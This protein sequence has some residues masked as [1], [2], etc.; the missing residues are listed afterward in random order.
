[1]TWMVECD[2]NRSFVRLEAKT[3]HANVLVQ[4]FEGVEGFQIVM[5]DEMRS[6][7]R[8]RSHYLPTAFE[9]CQVLLA[10][11]SQPIP[12]SDLLKGSS[13]AYPSLGDPRV[14]PYLVEYA[15]G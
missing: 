1:M 3:T 10:Q 7:P 5:C 2:P 15:H 12:I 4:E 9:S 6:T 13:A 8:T 14:G 11:H